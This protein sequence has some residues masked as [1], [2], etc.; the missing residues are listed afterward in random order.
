MT[1]LLTPGQQHEIGVA[2]E[3]MEQGAV[4]RTI[5]RPRVRP[6]RIVVIKATLRPNFVRFCADEAIGS[7]LPG[8]GTRD[9][10]DPLKKKIIGLETK[11]NA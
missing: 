8:V 2:E 5:G 4:R 7:R 10:V 9:G 11:L 3:L 1:F 6:G